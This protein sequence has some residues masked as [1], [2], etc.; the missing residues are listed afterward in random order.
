M[1]EN[2]SL[3]WL[4]HTS[5]I[6]SGLSSHGWMRPWELFLQRLLALNVAGIAGGESLA[7]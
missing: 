5:S 3:S 1:V 4:L 6:S 7:N 2:L